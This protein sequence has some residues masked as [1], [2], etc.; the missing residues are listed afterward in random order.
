MESVYESGVGI[1]SVSEKR[2]FTDWHLVGVSKVTS[3][4]TFYA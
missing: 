2:K 3:K 4:R 1:G